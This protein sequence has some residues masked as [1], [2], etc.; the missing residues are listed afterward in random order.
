M[1]GLFVHTKSMIAKQEIISPRC[2][3]LNV[4]NLK[5]IEVNTVPTS[6]EKGNSVAAMKNSVSQRSS[7][8]YNCGPQIGATFKKRESKHSRCSR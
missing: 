8:L 3:S 4:E 7:P 1:T 6:A 5:I 2:F